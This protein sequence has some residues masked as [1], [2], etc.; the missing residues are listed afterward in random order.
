MNA[1]G[2][3]VPR[4]VQPE[5]YGEPPVYVC[6]CHEAH[7]VI[8]L[9]ALCRSTSPTTPSS[10]YVA[11]E[12]CH[13]CIVEEIERLEAELAV[14]HRRLRRAEHATDP[15]TNEKIPPRFLTAKG[16]VA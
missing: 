16:W 15:V 6:R 4:T 3:H 11:L 9:C 1:K 10:P 12:R 13:T 2:G 7:G 14:R 5:I 8:H